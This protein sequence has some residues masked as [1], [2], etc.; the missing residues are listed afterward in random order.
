MPTTTDAMDALMGRLSE[1]S[2]RAAA[3]YCRVHGLPASER[4]EDLV[5]ELRITMPDG[6]HDGLRDAKAA[7]AAGMDRA[8]EATLVASMQ[9][10]GIRAAQRVFGGQ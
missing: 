5:R 7:L 2:M 8:A 6:L 10:A 3:E 1:V 4:A 9:L